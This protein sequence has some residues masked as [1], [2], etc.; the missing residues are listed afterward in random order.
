[1]GFSRNIPFY[2]YIPA[3][4]L[5]YYYLYENGDIDS[6]IFASYLADHPTDS[7]FQ[8]GAYD[9]VGTYYT[10][11]I[12]WLNMVE[13]FFWLSTSSSYIVKGETFTYDEVYVELDTGTSLAYLD[14]KNGKKFMNKAASGNR[15]F[16]WFGTWYL[17]CDLE[18]FESVFI[19]IGGYYFEIPPSSFVRNFEEY[20]Y[21]W[22][23]YGFR[24]EDIE[25]TW[26][27][28][29]TLFRSYYNVWDEENAL[30][31]FALRTGSD[32]TVAPYLA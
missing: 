1:M 27:F 30:L 12:V 9:E 21:K 32:A 25:G 6:L 18:M 5:F 26:L 13:D 24:W 23:D 20:G 7:F 22:C 2:G 15:G 31:G 4:A 10:G 3:G 11:D 17:K 14:K 19:E 29:D 8:V 28:G 16:K